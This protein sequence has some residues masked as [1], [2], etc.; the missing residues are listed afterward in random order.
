MLNL[1]L[2]KILLQSIPVLINIFVH[3][4]IIIFQWS[5]FDGVFVFKKK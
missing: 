1:L 5:N 2:I 4:G 3:V